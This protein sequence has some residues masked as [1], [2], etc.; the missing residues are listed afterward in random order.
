L[1]ERINVQLIMKKL[2]SAKPEFTQNRIAIA[3]R[4]LGK[5]SGA[6]RNVKEQADFFTSRGIG[7]D[8]YAER[9]DKSNFAGS[10]AR[11][12]KI[13]R[14]PLPGY[15]KRKAFEWQVKL[16][17]AMNDSALLISHGDI[18]TDG[19][20]SIHNCVHLAH[21]AIYGESLPKHHAVGRI[22][23]SII[24]QKKYRI[25]VTNSKLAANDLAKRYRLNPSKIEVVYPGYDP[26]QFNIQD[27]QTNRF[28]GREPI[29]FPSD[30]LLIGLITSGDFRKRN[31]DGL[32]KAIPY[33]DQGINVLVMGK[34]RYISQY[35]MLAKE[36]NVAHRIIWKSVS[37]D[38]HL[39]YHAVDFFILPAHIEE[40]GRTALEAMACGKPVV[41]G[42]MVGCAELLDESTRPCKLKDVTPQGIA[43]GISWMAG[44]DL[45]TR[46]NLGNKLNKIAKSYTSEL[47]TK[48]LMQLIQD[49]FP[50][51]FQH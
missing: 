26:D 12:N 50:G 28:K 42:P 34:D 30:K 11:L 13:F 43:Q 37:R 41:L 51:I 17:L 4:Q 39:Y 32:I 3:I 46:L 20:L 45:Q 6:A 19:V 48:K 31:V 21:E 9:L 44:Q 40:F 14:L 16:R 5:N 24:N 10:K 35:Q 23:D 47:Q 2:N 15:Y 38:V 36:L 29:G 33:L 49:S 18:N 22:H 1:P 27:M 25:L 7:V 8:I